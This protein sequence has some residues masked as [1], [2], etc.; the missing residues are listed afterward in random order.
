MLSYIKNGF[1]SAFSILLIIIFS[2]TY[3]F[4]Q[5]TEASLTPLKTTYNP[6]MQ[7]GVQGGFNFADII[8][9]DAG[10]NNQVKI[11]LRLG[12]YAFLPVDDV[13]GFQ[14]ELIFFS[15]KG[16]RNGNA[17]FRSTYLEIPLL[18]SYALDEHFRLIAGI[19]P[20]FLL[21]AYVNDG[22][23]DITSEIRTVDFGLAFGVY[24]KLLEELSFGMRIVPGLSKVGESGEENTYNVN[25]EISVAYD[26][27]YLFQ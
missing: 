14:P 19:Q 13:W 3:T 27:Y 26:L 7:L 16:T 17:K 4:G 2:N 21:G 6:E 25:V 11:G 5:N 24:Y 8:G 10:A 15:Q 1:S 18:A 23:G 12:A 20:S 22:R 9:K